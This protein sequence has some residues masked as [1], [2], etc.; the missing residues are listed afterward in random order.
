MHFAA[1]SARLY[2]NQEQAYSGVGPV[3]VCVCVCVF[4]RA[5]MRV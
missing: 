1:L 3:R 2:V 4:V 5:C